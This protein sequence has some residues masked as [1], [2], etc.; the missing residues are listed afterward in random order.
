MRT[1]VESARWRFVQ[2][3]VVF[4]GRTERLRPRRLARKR[5]WAVHLGRCLTCPPNTVSHFSVTGSIQAFAALSDLFSFDSFARLKVDS[6][7]GYKD[8]VLSP[9]FMKR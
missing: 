1:F 2:L 4:H 3:R 6:F 7:A 5:P 8:L 9:V